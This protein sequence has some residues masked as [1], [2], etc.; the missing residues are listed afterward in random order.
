LFHK[1]AHLLERL[2]RHVAVVQAD[3]VDLAAVDAA[4]GVDLGE[5]GVLRVPNLA[6]YGHWAAVG[7]GLAELYLCI[8]N[9]GAIFFSTADAAATNAIAAKN[10]ID[11][12]PYFLMSISPTFTSIARR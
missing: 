7:R 10:M 1:F 4:F 2:G 8:A 11:A 9:T 3:Q 6:I 5:I 12:S